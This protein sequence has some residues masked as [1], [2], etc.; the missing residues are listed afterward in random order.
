[1][2]IPDNSAE[3][4]LQQE[5]REMFLVDTQQ[6]L[7]LYFDIA[8]QLQPGSWIGDIQS[9]YRAIHTI[10]G[11]AVCWAGRWCWKICSQICGIWK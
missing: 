11:G 10:K 8:Q 1:M 2:L 3:A 6:Q 5:L 9:I 4:Q 7:E